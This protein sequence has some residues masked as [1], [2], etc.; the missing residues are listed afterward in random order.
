MVLSFLATF[1]NVS[2]LFPKLY[3]TIPSFLL[4]SFSEC[5]GMEQPFYGLHSPSDEVSMSLETAE[6]VTRLVSIH[7]SI[8][9]V[10]V[11]NN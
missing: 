3:N 8:G 1:L 10:Q 2:V 9:D 7:R 4:T 11:I 6:Y 5:R